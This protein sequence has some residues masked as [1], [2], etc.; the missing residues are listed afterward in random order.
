MSA[1]PELTP[2]A[3]TCRKVHIL[4]QPAVPAD[5][6]APP[7]AARIDEG[8][9]KGDGGLVHGVHPQAPS[10]HAAEGPGYDRLQ[11]KSS[12]QAQ[13]AMPHLPGPAGTLDIPNPLNMKVIE[14]CRKCFCRMVTAVR[15]HPQGCCWSA[16]WSSYWCELE[17]HGH[18]QVSVKSLL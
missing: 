8:C 17:A 4:P 10:T 11:P 16:G 18:H 3:A 7:E 1:W 15:Q 14:G 9:D 12:K 13:Q 2:R 5:V 6:E